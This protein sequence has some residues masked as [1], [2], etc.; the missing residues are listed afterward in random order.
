MPDRK[1]PA[2]RRRAAIRRI[3]EN[4]PVHS[5]TA[6]LES[7]KAEGF[8]VGQSSVSRDLAELGVV[9]VDGRYVTR[10]S[11][12]GASSAGG[13]LREVASWIHGQ[14]PAGPHL[15]VVRTPPGH[16]SAVGLAIDRARWPEVVGSVAGDDTVFVATAS[17]RDQARVQ[18]R[19][20]TYIGGA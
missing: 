3:I 11:L 4:G 13:S 16:A 1:T 15:L 17:R 5:Q 8:D 10:D 9:K 19:L 20:T 12:R 6:L 7:L 18:A 2:A 14:R